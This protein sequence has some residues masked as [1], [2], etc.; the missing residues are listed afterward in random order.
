MLNICPVWVRYYCGRGGWC[1]LWN[2]VRL[3][4]RTR[5]R[6]L[7]LLGSTEDRHR[8]AG[9]KF[10]DPCLSQRPRSGYHRSLLFIAVSTQRQYRAFE[11]EQL[12]DSS[13]GSRDAMVLF[14]MIRLSASALQGSCPGSRGPLIDDDS[15]RTPPRCY[16]QGGWGATSCRL[17]LGKSEPRAAPSHNGRS[18][19]VRTRASCVNSPSPSIMQSFKLSPHGCPAASRLWLHSA[20]L[21]AETALPGLIG[22][23][24]ENLIQ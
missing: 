17:M 20:A 19:S 5:C 16:F 9:P 24:L 13:E 12:S 22:L 1:G 21:P 11:V 14:H 18:P 7:A 2:G 3:R 8:L 10:C 6:G 23:I 15:S 4:L